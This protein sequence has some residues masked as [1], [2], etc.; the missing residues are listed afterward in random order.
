MIAE[1]GVL[2]DTKLIAEPWDAGGLYQVGISRSAGAGRNGTAA[3]A[4][5]CAASGAARLALSAP[6]PRACAAVPTFIKHT[7]RTPVHSL[8]F[9]TCHDGFTLWDLV[10]YNHKHNEA[11][12][13]SNRDGMDENFSWNCGTEGPSLDPD[14]NR[15]RKRQ[16][17]NL[18]ATLMLSQGVPMILAGDEF[19]RTQKGNNNAWCQ[20]NDISWV[21]WNLAEKNRDFLRFVTMLIA[22]RKRHPALTAALVFSGHR[23]QQ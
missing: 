19:L 10:S 21:D 13:E 5:T 14:V 22:L 9:V 4:T 7:G 3:T 8:N 15:L 1:D 23:S 16:A 17:K 18:L 12:G 2:A 20:D 6:W 11:N